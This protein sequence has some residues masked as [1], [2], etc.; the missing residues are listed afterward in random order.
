MSKPARS[1][2]VA[3]LRG[4]R[5][6]AL[7]FSPD[8]TLMVTGGF[9]HTDLWDVASGANMSALDRSRHCFAADFRRWSSPGDHDGL[10]K[11][12]RDRKDSS[13]VLCWNVANGRGVQ[14]LRGLTSPISQI[15]FSPGVR[16]RRTREQLAG[17]DLGPAY[18]RAE[19]RAERPGGI[20]PDNAAMAFSTDGLKF[21]CSSGTG[22]KLWEMSSGARSAGGSCH[23]A[24]AITWH[25]RFGLADALPSGN[26]VRGARP[27]PRR[28]LRAVSSRLPAPR[29]TRL[30][31]D[32]SHRGDRNV[33]S[34]CVLS[35]CAA[36]LELH[37][38]G[39]RDDRRRRG[40]PGRS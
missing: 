23:W 2:S 5:V 3:R 27:C 14:T 22:A 28:L 31:P 19:A 24:F 21:A 36:R 25:S 29:A 1:T 30:G 12:P 6:D 20:T 18:R 33:Q 40:A 16:T 38:G 17:R 32:A 26:Q 15:L 4:S 35:C 7:A 39:W 10:A 8:G 11:R 13:E 34:P 9:Q 37:C